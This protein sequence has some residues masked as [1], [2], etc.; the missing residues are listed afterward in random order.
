MYSRWDDLVYGSVLVLLIL[1][2]SF[3]IGVTI[4]SAC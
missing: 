2:V 4:G 3:G 1:A